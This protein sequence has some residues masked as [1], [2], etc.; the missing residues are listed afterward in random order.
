[1]KHICIG[2]CLEFISS[3]LYN[4]YKSFTYDRISDF[5]ANAISPKYIENW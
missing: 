1:M 3:T 5:C 2:F 4:G